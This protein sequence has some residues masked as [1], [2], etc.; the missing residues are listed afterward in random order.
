MGAPRASDPDSHRDAKAQP[1]LERQPAARHQIVSRVLLAVARGCEQPTG[2]SSDRAASSSGAG[3]RGRCPRFPVP[4]GPAPQLRRATSSSDR[5]EPRDS[6][7]TAARYLSRVAKSIAANPGTVRSASSTRLTLSKEL[8]PADGGHP[9]HAGDDVPDRD[10][11]SGLSLMCLGHHFAGGSPLGGQV[12]AQPV[13]SRRDRRC[14]VTQPLQQL[15]G[16]R[17]REANVAKIVQHIIH[18]LRRPAAETQE[19]IRHLDPRW[20]APWRARMIS[21]DSRRR[22]SRRATRRWMATAQSSPMPRGCTRW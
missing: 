22:F 14:L 1:P 4:R 12:L 8:R 21:S 15:H 3:L 5:F 9:P 20:R 16:E 2:W 18:A 13:E 6:S 7:S 19:T 11:R 17:A 10:V